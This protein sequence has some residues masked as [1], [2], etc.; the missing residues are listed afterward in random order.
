MQEEIRAASENDFPDVER[1]RGLHREGGLRTP[2]E[3][4]RDL[5]GT[6][7]RGLQNGA[8]LDLRKP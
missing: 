1:F 7:E 8:V 4:A 2:E 3:A 6:L 5:W